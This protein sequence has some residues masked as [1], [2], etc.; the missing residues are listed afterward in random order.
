ML[1]LQI[2]LMSEV[3]RLN[4]DELSQ[5]VGGHWQD[6]HWNEQKQ[7]PLR[8]LQQGQQ[9]WVLV[10]QEHTPYMFRKAGDKKFRYESTFLQWLARWTDGWCFA[11]RRVKEQREGR[12]GRARV[13][14]A[15]SLP[16]FAV[17]L[18]QRLDPSVTTIGSC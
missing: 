6:R 1:L 5:L 14:I 17:M 13:R 3:P 12:K 11:C 7:S 10:T 16:L 9:T 4:V 15:V 18:P 8:I 2:V